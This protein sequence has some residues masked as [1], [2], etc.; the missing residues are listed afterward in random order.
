MLKGG[1]VLGSA[2]AIPIEEKYPDAK[3]EFK[4]DQTLAKSSCVKR[5]LA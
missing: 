1:H 3:P 2:S 5:S 4:G